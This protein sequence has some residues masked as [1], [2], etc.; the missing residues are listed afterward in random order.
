MKSTPRCT[1][2][3]VFEKDGCS[4]TTKPTKQAPPTITMNKNLKSDDELV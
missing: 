2:Y 4:V 3:S 1:L